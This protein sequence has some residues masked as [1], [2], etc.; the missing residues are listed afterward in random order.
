[1]TDDTTPSYRVPNLSILYTE[2][3]L[4]N[5]LLLIP[6]SEKINSQHYFAYERQIDKLSQ[7]LL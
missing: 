4:P 7:F 2:S 6:E 5:S 3:L 1:M